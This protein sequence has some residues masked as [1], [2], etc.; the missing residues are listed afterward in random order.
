MKTGARINVVRVGQTVIVDGVSAIVGDV[1]EVDAEAGTALVAWR[2]RTTV[3]ILDD[4]V[5][6]DE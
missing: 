6:V 2:P 3:E 1:L 5:L 4:L